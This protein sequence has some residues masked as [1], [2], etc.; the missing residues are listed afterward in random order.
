MNF[1]EKIW[2]IIPKRVKAYFYFKNLIEFRENIKWEYCRLSYSQEG[3]DL[4]IDRILYNENL[5]YVD[6]GAHHPFRFSNTY[7]FY[8]RGARGINI[9]ASP[10]S[11]ELFKKYRPNDVNLEL[12][13]SNKKEV[14]NFSIF[15][16]PALNSF[17]EDLVQA[18]EN[19]GWK[20]IRKI[21][22]ETSKLSDVLDNYLP[23]GQKID[24]LSIDVEGWDLKVLESN[25][26]EKYRP[27]L[28]CI[29]SNDTDSQTSRQNI[30]SYLNLIG[31]TE[32]Y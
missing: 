25:D 17:D 23:P 7:L 4:L 21:R 16:E 26:W 2:G 10:G 6:V 32:P 11:M 8:R 15:E 28:I 5:F 19:N 22:F 20:V 9:D 29:E 14:L 13:I 18:R 31:Y 12:P 30:S 27:K 3:E 24:F 1:N